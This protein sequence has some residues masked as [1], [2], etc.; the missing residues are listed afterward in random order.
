M[1]KEVLTRTE[2]CDVQQIIF[3]GTDETETP[4]KGRNPRKGCKWLHVDD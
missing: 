4:K 2:N 1:M 3:Y